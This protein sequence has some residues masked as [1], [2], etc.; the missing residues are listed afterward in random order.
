MTGAASF[1]TGIFIEPGGG[2]AE[3]VDVEQIQ[4]IGPR[5]ARVVEQDTAGGKSFRDAKRGWMKVVTVGLVL[6]AGAFALAM[7]GVRGDADD[8]ELMKFKMGFMAGPGGPKLWILSDLL[9][10]HLASGWALGSLAAYAAGVVAVMWP[11]RV[12]IMGIA[13]IGRLLASVMAV[14]GLV[15]GILVSQR[16]YDVHGLL[17][18]GYYDLLTWLIFLDMAAMILVNM[19]VA[20]IAGRGGYHRLA[21]ATG[22][23]MAVQVVGMLMLMVALNVLRNAMGFMWVS[24]GVYAVGGAGVTLVG[25]FLVTRMGW[26]LLVRRGVR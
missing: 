24:A 12:G 11:E 2:L 13:G 3:K 18:V 15:F 23:M 20:G 10:A 26:E 14:A 5:A 9:R 6:L 22:G 7:V 8:A 17:E 4:L 1:G 25:V 21:K 16:A 19:R